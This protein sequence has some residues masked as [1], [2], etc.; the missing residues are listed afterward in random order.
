MSHTPQNADEAGYVSFALIDALVDLLINRGIITPQDC[1]TILETAAAHLQV[2]PNN[3][4]ARSAEFV[5]RIFSTRKNSNNPILIFFPHPGAYDQLDR[6]PD[7]E[8]GG[9]GFESAAPAR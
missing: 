5:R 2:A 7:F 3:A 9:C 6:S 8:S 1:A 4:S